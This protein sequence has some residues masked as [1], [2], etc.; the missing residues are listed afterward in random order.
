[1]AMDGHPEV[2]RFVSGPWSDPIA[3]RAFVEQR[4]RGP[5][6]SGLGYWVVCQGGEPLSFLG[7]VLLIPADGTRREIEIGWL[8]LQTEWRQGFATEAAT[9]VL[10][11]AFV[12]LE[13]P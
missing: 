6:P 7:W 10:W 12:T 3:H 5:Y 2:I 13:L 8:L 9:P 11:H 1:M 4:T